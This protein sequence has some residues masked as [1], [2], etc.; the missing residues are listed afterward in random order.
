MKISML[1]KLMLVG[2]L[3]TVLFACGGGDSTP[4]DTSTT[5]QGVAAAGIFQTGTVDIY[6][7]KADGTVGDLLK[8][9]NIVP[10]D[11]GQY[12]ANIGTY[13]GA[14]VAYAYGT[15]IDE[16]TGATIT[17][18][19]ASPLKAAVPT[20]T[21]KP[22]L[23]KLN[24]T[25]LTTAAATKAATYSD[26]NIATAN[27]TL[28]SAFGI[29]DIT[30][31]S[32]VTA[33]DLSKTTITDD[34]KK[35]TTLLALLSQYAATLS[36]NPAA[37]TA[38][39][40]VTALAKIAAGI[41]PAATSGATPTVSPDTAYALQTAATD[42]SGKTTAAVTAIK[43]VTIA[44]TYLSDVQSGKLLNGGTAIT[45]Y[46]LKLRT[47]G[48]G[49]IGS[50]D[51]ISITLPAGVTIFPSAS[52]GIVLSGVA[53]AATTSLTANAAGTLLSLASS[54]QTGLAVG[55]FL[56]IYCGYPSNITP[57]LAGI[58]MTVNKVADL[59]GNPISVT[60]EKF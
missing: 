8:S 31:I 13:S 15:Y 42:L 39:E 50:I 14:V 35:Y 6:A 37:P 59:Q 21:I 12:T 40:V 58:T 28:G 17:L 9:V 24:I 22:G 18:P 51:K 46:P 54:A 53:S 27:S 2:A 60:V 23:V 36:S 30:A 41:T 43:T 29:T 49:Q 25:A 57:T 1:F 44:S 5:I 7:V 4:V 16:S 56:T 38:S 20:S 47:T 19:K 48:T 26:S 32:P 55:E 33:S 3:S 34:Q 52:T 10:T 11:N 45:I